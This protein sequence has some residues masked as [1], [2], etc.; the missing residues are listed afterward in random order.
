MQDPYPIQSSAD[1]PAPPLMNIHADIDMADA[2][3]SPAVP[4]LNTT[5]AVQRTA[6]PTRNINGN[7]DL[8]PPLPAKAAIHGA[9]ARRYLNEK[10]TG[11]LMEGMKRIAVEQY[12]HIA[13]QVTTTTVF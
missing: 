1:S 9:P 7:V 5:P 6:T 13:Q 4:S 12:V 8:P 3:P 2:A 11:V 10:V